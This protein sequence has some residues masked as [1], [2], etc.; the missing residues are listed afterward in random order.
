MSEQSSSTRRSAGTAFFNPFWKPEPRWEPT[1]TTTPSAPIAQA[2]S[3][4]E[5][6]VST[7]FE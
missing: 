4:V 3:I 5:R 1:W 7:D 6:I 2:V